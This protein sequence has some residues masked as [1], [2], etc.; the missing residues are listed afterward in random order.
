[1]AL[2]A[3]V[4]RYVAGTDRR[5]TLVASSS[6]S[7][8]FLIDKSWHITPDTAADRRL[9]DACVPRVTVRARTSTGP[10]VRASRT[11]ATGAS[12][13]IV[14]TRAGSRPPR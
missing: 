6:W 10:P 1:M 13:R 14:L 2:S 4:G 8:A 7:H 3:S 9:Y 11:G 5:V 12:P